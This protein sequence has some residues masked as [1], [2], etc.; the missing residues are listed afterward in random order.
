MT[1]I[2]FE[3]KN[4]LALEKPEGLASIPERNLHTD[5]LLAQAEAATG[6]K[7]FV[8]HRLDKDVSGVILFA[9][10]EET[11]RY[12]NM[13]FEARRVNKTYVAIVHGSMRKREGVIDVP[14]RQCGSGRM[15]VDMDRGK[16]ALTEYTVKKNLPDFAYLE[17]R[18]ATGRRHQIRVHLYHNGHAIVG[19]RLYGDPELQKNFPRLM[20]HA[21]ALEFRDP[22]GNRIKAQSPVPK[23]FLDFGAEG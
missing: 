1:T 12:L 18:P 19:D 15:A 22:T 3:T 11:H 4:I 17:V 9:K 5:C 20:L 16:P 14:I 6:S 8:V 10:D 13:E 7:L 23:A 21:H 2:L